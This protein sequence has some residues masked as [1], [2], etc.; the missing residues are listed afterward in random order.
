MDSV[1]ELLKRETCA[2][3][4]D[5]NGEYMGARISAVFVILVTSTLGALIPVISTKTSV[6]FLKMPSWLFFGAKYFGT[7]VIVATAFIHLLQPANENL[8][9]DCLSATFR[10]YPWAF[11]IAL[12]SLFSLFFFELLAFNYINK[13]LESTNGVPHSH[14]HFGELGKKE[15]DIEDEEE[16]HENSTPVVSASKGLY[17]DHFSHA[18]EHQDP[19]NLDT[20]LQQMD[21]EQYYGQLVSTIV[22]EFGIVFHSVFV[23]LTLAVS[24]DEFKTLYVVI[25]FHQTFEGLGLGTRIAGTR[26]PKGKEYLPYL[27]IIAYGLTTPI[28]IAIG[29]GVRQSYA[30]N[31]QTALIV[32]GV[33]DSVSAGILI[34]TGIVE[35]MAHEFLYSDQFKGPGSFKRMVAAYIVVVFGAGLMALL[36]RWA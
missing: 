4:S 8:S 31:S 23:G 3:D 6:S 35:L 32:N 18:A 5:Y 36:G 20:P 17:P 29:L 26:W 19:E 22:L 1:T 16:E 33:F 34:Y 30:P 9:N 14:S 21:K 10:V 24:G 13:K 11:G 12:L 2:T 25:V 28:A 27:F 15:S 7:G